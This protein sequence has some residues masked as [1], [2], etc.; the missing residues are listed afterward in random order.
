MIN[1]KMD[2]DN[3]IKKARYKVPRKGW[4][5]NSLIL[6]VDGDIQVKQF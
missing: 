4:E 3:E 5:K 1:E 2:Q 6:D